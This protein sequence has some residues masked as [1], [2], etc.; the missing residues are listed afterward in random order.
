MLGRRREW[1]AA[2]SPQQ[3]QRLFCSGRPP[4]FPRLRDG[5][6]FGADTAMTSA[7]PGISRSTP[8]LL[9]TSAAENRRCWLV[10]TLATARIRSDSVPTCGQGA[11]LL[12]ARGRRIQSSA[13]V[14]GEGN[15]PARGKEGGAETSGGGGAGGL[16]HQVSEL[17]AGEVTSR[18]LYMGACQNFVEIVG[19]VCWQ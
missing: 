2:L 3:R 16:P 17:Y 9:A 15:A 8:L 19:D 4:P 10:G 12:V 14:A 6:G 13:I 18:Q 11:R 7:G 1:L 5:L